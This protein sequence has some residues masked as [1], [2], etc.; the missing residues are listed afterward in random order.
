LRLRD[1]ATLGREGTLLLADPRCS[2]QHAQL[3]RVGSDWIVSDGGSHNGTWVRGRRTERAILRD[4]D[5]IRLGDSVLVYRDGPLSEDAS[6]PGV[7]GRS[8]AMRRLRSALARVASHPAPVH[9]TG[10]SGTGKSLVAQHLHA[11]SGRTGAFLPVN[12]PSIPAPLAES[13][14][15]GHRR[16]AFSGANQAHIGYLQAAHQG[17]LFLDEVA[18]LPSPLQATLLRALD[19]GEVLPL[20]ANR[21]EQVDVRVISAT[22]RDLASRIEVGGFRGDLY[23]RLAGVVLHLPSL[24]E[25]PE[26]LFLLMRSFWPELPKLRMSLVERMLAY[27]WPYNVRELQQ[28]TVQLQV[29]APLDWSAVLDGRLAPA[30]PDAPEPLQPLE[31]PDREALET[32]LRAHKGV[33]SAVARASGR[34]RK[35]VYR[36]L[37]R[38][39]LDPQ[40]FR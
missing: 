20:G 23:M 31:P 21:A 5:W 4:G 27:P 7:L 9:L 17:T 26:D 1:A 10:A 33:I 28:I 39:G 35:Q 19:T 8:P 13:L 22:N 6:L 36:W 16:G 12:A 32:L 25:R 18:D 14:F 29:T 3:R 37:D 2:R 40:D 15:F 24:E 11:L 30:H 38:H 34:S